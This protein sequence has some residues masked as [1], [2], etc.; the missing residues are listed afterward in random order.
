MKLRAIVLDMDGTVTEFNLDFIEM[1]RAALAE[2]KK[3]N[4]RTAELTDQLSIYLMLKKVR[5]KLNARTYAQL[6]RRLYAQLASMETKAAQEVILQA[7]VVDT[8]RDLRKRNLK[9]GLLTN[10]GRAGTNLT[11]KR[12]GLGLFFETVVTRDDC[13]EMKPD[14]GP[15]R[16]VLAR[17]HSRVEEA[18]LVGDGVMDMLAAKAAGLRS[19]AVGTGPIDISRLLE[20]EPDYVLRSISD[21]PTLVDMLGSESDYIAAKTNVLP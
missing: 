13:E 18:I 21:L 3:M 5:T 19:A 1:R 20:T 8:L 10:N 15:V 16:Q 4:V 7:G 6:R 12:F 14:A 9:I 2:L 17:L 11:L